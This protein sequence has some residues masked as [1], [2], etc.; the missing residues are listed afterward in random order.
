VGCVSKISS[1]ANSGLERRFPLPFEGVDVNFCR[2]PTCVSYG[3]NPD[4]YKRPN[5]APPA[6][7]GVLRGVVSGAQHEEFFDCPHCT[8]TARLKNNRAIAEEYRRLKGLQERDPNAPACSTE[9]CFAHGLLPE[10]HPEF[11]WKFG[12]TAGGDPR[13]RCRLCLKTFSAGKPARRHRR[14]DKNRL[15]F[16]MVCNDMSLSKI[17]KIA[18]ISYRD[19]YGKI[20]FFYDQVRTFTVRRQ[21]FSQVDFRTAGSRFA[22][23]SQTLTINWPTKRKRA[24]V[25]VQ[26]LCTA[27]ARSG[28]IMEASLQ[29]DPAMTMQE[30]EL[31]AVAA[32]E[33]DVSVAFREHARA[34]TK[35]EF[36]AHLAKLLAQKKIDE[37]EL[38]QLPHDGVLVR[39]DILQFAHAMRL[40]EHLAGTDAPLV[41]VMDDDKGLRQAL[42]SIFAPEV[43]AGRA[44]IAIVS[45]DKGMTNDMRNQVV[46][47][48]QN[49][50]AA[51]TGF[52]LT[53]LRA[54]SDQ[55]FADLVDEEVATR[56]IG[57]DLRQAFQYPFP[58]KSEP[59]RRIRLLTDSPVHD[60]R[61]KARLLRLATL[62][63]VDSYYH[64][65]RSNVR[66][67]ARPSISA[68]SVKQTWDRQYLYKPATM[69]KLVEIYRFYHNWCELGADKKTPAMRL[70]LARGRIYERDFM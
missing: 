54:L 6:P 2:T 35:T 11:Y 31:R 66:F 33:E 62:R 21:D 64:K 57:L 34:W 3:V 1:T 47:D 37:A 16:Q 53:Q 18:D 44:E 30:A 49:A 22:T 7:P 69:A 4:P 20:D 14:S 13:W 36:D 8:S 50:L 56:I 61:Q 9:G 40:R 32:N 58:R 67:A 48:G 15:I 52:G 17:S 59:N 38:Y 39:Y 42:C 23:D 55:D 41:L 65:F 19:L 70:G 68:G 63:S 27:H 10:E 12:K 29:L 46:A 51:A 26:H 45:F 60:Y 25:M 5:G 43:K 24:P 28:Y